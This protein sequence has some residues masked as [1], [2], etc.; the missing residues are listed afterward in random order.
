MTHLIIILKYLQITSQRPGYLSQVIYV[1]IS[2]SNRF[3]FQVSSAKYYSSRFLEIYF[4]IYFQA[5][6]SF[7]TTNISHTQ[8]LFQVKGQLFTNI[9]SH[10][11]QV[12]G[13]DSTAYISI[14]KIFSTEVQGKQLHCSHIFYFL[15]APGF[16]ISHLNFLGISFKPVLVIQLGHYL[17][18]LL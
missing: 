3:S 1:H 15:S 16:Y 18:Q 2:I 5:R 12:Q 11:S 7:L 4:T 13:K 14:T 9:F 6:Y 17:H 10:A 8:H